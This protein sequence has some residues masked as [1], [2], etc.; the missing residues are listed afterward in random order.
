[1][2]SISGG[3]KLVINHWQFSQVM[4]FALFPSFHQNLRWFLDWLLVLYMPVSKFSYQIIYPKRNSPKYYCLMKYKNCNSMDETDMKF[5][6]LERKN[7]LFSSK[8]SLRVPLGRPLKACSPEEGQIP[9]GRELWYQTS[10]SLGWSHGRSW[11]DPQ[12]RQVEK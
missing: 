10:N 7:A 1:M 9:P 3:P 11:K 6:V 2:I 4:I 12:E 5:L 8:P